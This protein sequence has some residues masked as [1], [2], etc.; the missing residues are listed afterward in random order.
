[1]NFCLSSILGLIGTLAAQAAN[2]ATRPNILF[3]FADNWQYEHAGAKGCAAVKTPLFD[4]IAREGARFTNAYCPV[5]SCGPARSSVGSHGCNKL[6][7]PSAL[8][9]EETFPEP[10]GPPHLCN[11]YSLD[12]C[13]PSSLRSR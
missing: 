5:P 9:W 3:L 7:N 2:S 4:R 10:N 6:E 8:D 12:C 1:M 13:S 11:I